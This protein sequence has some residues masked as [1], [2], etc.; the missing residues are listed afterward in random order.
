MVEYAVE[1]KPSARKELESLPDSMLA[2]VVQRLESLRRNPKPAGVKKLKGYKDQWRIRV[3]D[4]RVL[5]IIDDEA[6]LVS[7]TRIAHR[8]EVYR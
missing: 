4:W 7:I 5:Y 2:R 6:R 3:G 1:V 8:R